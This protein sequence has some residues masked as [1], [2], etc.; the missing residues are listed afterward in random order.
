[1][2]TTG[3]NNMTTPQEL[4]KALTKRFVQVTLSDG[5]V[6]AGFI[7]N[8]EDFKD[9]MPE[10]MLLINGLLRDQVKVSQVVDVQFPAR[11]ETTSIPV[12]DPEKITKK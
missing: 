6:H 9:E 12:I 11:E 5:S 8:P 10:N 1:M 2:C 7:G 3:R 4:R